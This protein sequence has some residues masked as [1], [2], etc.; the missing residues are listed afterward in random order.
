MLF[1][2]KQNL[3]VLIELETRK[4]ITLDQFQ[5]TFFFLL[6]WSLFYLSARPLAVER[7]KKFAKSFEN[8]FDRRYQDHRHCPAVLMAAVSLLSG[9]PAFWWTSKTAHWNMKQSQIQPVVSDRQLR[10][11][12]VELQRLLGRICFPDFWVTE[13]RSDC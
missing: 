9:L 7:F 3:C 6:I 1:E 11:V 5:I 2:A 8:V 12:N 10:D 4:S 13:M